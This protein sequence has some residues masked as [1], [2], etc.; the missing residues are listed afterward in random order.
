MI[1]ARLS[2]HVC[3]R[4]PRKSSRRLSVSP[5]VEVLDC[6]RTRHVSDQGRLSHR[7]RRQLTRPI[8]G[9]RQQRRHRAVEALLLRRLQ[10]DR[11]HIQRQEN[12]RDSSARRR[13]RSRHRR[14]RARAHHQPLRLRFAKSAARFA[15]TTFPQLWSTPSSPPKT[16]ASSST[17]ASTS[18]ASWAPRGPTCATPATTIKARAPSPCRSRAHFS[19]PTSA[20]GAASSPN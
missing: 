3:S 11:R 18:S 17:A 4:T 7:K 2:G 6:R 15:T 8:H 14:H 12:Q 19:S 13:Q 20:P 9:A 10:R 5:T 16:S 1:N